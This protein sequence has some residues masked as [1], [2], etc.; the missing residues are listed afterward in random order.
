MLQHFPAGV[1]KIL[2]WI[3]INTVRARLLPSYSAVLVTL[4]PDLRKE[5]FAKTVWLGANQLLPPAPCSAILQKRLVFERVL[6][7]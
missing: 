4:R 2:L 1:N 7:E 3:E 5:F 6:I